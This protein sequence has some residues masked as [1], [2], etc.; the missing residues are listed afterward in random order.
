ML[1]RWR[2]GPR[3]DAYIISYVEK[4]E[5]IKKSIILHGN[6]QT[7]KVMRKVSLLF[8]AAVFSV[9]LFAGGIVTN[10]NQSAA[11]VRWLVRD[12]SLGIDAVY[13]NPAGLSKLG[14][15]FH[16]SLNNQFIFQTQT[17]T[18]DYPYLNGSPKSYEADVKALLYPD[19]FAAYN[20]GKFSFSFGVVPIGGG[21]SADF[22]DG[23]ASFEMPVSDL[24]PILGYNLK[25]VDALVAQYTGT[26]PHYRDVTGYSLKA[27]LNGSSVYLGFQ[28][29]VSYAINDLIQ[30][31]LGARYVTVNNSYEGHLTDIQIEAPQNYGGW[32]APGD[33]MNFVSDD[34]P[35][36]NAILVYLKGQLKESAAALASATE[37][38][39]VDVTQ[40]GNGWTG[41]IGVNISPSENLNI[42]LKYEHHTKIELTN[43][44]AVDSFAMFPDGA[45]SR[46]DLPGM[47]SAGVQ[48]R[49]IDRLTL[50]AGFHY[51]LDKTAYY[52]KTAIDTV[53]GQPVIEPDGI[54]YKQVDNKDFMEG[55]TW[56]LGLGAEFMV[57]KKF[58]ISAGY[59][60]VTTG[61]NEKYQSAIGYSLSTNTYGGGLVYNFTD[62]I[63]LNLG[64][65]YVI[66]QSDEVSAQTGNPIYS[67]GIDPPDQEFISYKNIYEKNTMVIGVG[68]DISF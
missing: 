34:I 23:I 49:P 21:G 26:D 35:P 8:L 19:I 3:K 4:I 30:V 48:F 51:Y 52:G 66:Y 45:K 28:G 43:E 60:H 36:T 9:N 6:N 15:G 24:V 31:S 17:I 42:A 58:G 40:T 44:T 61:A 27:A 25:G 5:V 62:K 54:S 56:E 57:T 64:F 38:G 53:T 32:Q 59:L 2:T 67:P 39:Y 13:Y 16:L 47:L 46:A 50:Q 14:N 20:I 12:A 41:I 10:T 68:L 37:D 18:C 55:N 1:E 29:N 22:A 11:W 65:D 7:K 33:Y 63:Q